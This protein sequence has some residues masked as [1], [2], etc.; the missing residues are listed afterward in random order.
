MV[1]G[2]ALVPSGTRHGKPTAPDVPGGA[3]GS[4][5]AGASAIVPSLAGQP[6][7]E[8]LPKA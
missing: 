3:P 5:D 4:P 2:F 6:N 1:V 8:A 7:D